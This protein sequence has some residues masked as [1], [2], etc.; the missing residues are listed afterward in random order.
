[1]LH[2]YTFMAKIID[3][4]CEY[5]T[6]KQTV[7][8]YCVFNHLILIYCFCSW[9]TLETQSVFKIF[10]SNYFDPFLYFNGRLQT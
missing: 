8:D 4:K 1:M 9:K 10:N 2:F 6:K 5:L 3:L 7:S